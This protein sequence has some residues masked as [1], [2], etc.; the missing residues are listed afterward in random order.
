MLP[1]R[2]GSGMKF[3][4]KL[5]ATGSR[6]DWGITLPENGIP[7]GVDGVTASGGAT[8]RPA[9]NFDCEKSPMR[10]SALGTTT[11]EKVELATCRVASRE[12]K[13]NVRS[14]PL[15]PGSF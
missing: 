13:K 3:L 5:C 9:G 8:A 4:M 15:Y 1:A 14:L 12:R 11:F 6:R 2:L 10:S 7:I